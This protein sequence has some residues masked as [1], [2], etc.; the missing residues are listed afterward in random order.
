MKRENKFKLS[1]QLYNSKNS[2]ITWTKG[3]EDDIKNIKSVRADIAVMSLKA[4]GSEVPD[5]IIESLKDT[6]EISPEAY[7]LFLKAKYAILNSKSSTDRELAQ[8]LFKKAIKI[9]PNYLEA[10][11]NYAMTMV[12][13]ISLKE[14][15]IF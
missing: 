6:N 12:L 9:E 7:E 14:L 15:L 11:Y 4:I 5:S 1:L 3:W 8:E 13:E 2:S 10:R